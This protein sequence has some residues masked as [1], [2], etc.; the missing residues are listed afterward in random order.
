MTIKNSEVIISFVC[1]TEDYDAAVAS[2]LSVGSLVVKAIADNLIEYYVTDNNSD[3]VAETKEDI[4]KIGEAAPIEDD[5]SGLPVPG[6]LS[7][8]LTLGLYQAQQNIN[9]VVKGLEGSILTNPVH[10]LLVGHPVAEDK[11]GVAALPDH[12]TYSQVKTG[13][14]P[15]YA[16]LGVLTTGVLGTALYKSGH[17]ENIATAAMGLAQGALDTVRDNDL[18]QGILGQ[19]YRDKFDQ[20]YPDYHG[21]YYQQESHNQY[22]PYHQQHYQTNFLIHPHQDLTNNQSHFSETEDQVKLDSEE[23]NDDPEVDYKPVIINTD[24]QSHDQPYVVYSYP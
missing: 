12:V 22:L 14:S 8:S 1:R 13:I 10:N 3:E 16:A 9:R 6:T 11:L 4:H 15:A 24:E 2:L 23:E 17:T 19:T 21:D 18:V 5:V 7:H 20:D